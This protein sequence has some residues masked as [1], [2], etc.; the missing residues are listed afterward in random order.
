MAIEITTGGVT[1]SY[2]Y[3]PYDAIYVDASGNVNTSGNGRQV[4]EAYFNG[5]KYY[6]EEL[7]VEALCLQREE[8]PQTGVRPANWGTPISDLDIF[9]P[10]VDIATYYRLM[11]RPYTSETTRNFY[12]I[13]SQLRSVR[14]PSCLTISGAA[15][16]GCTSLEMVE[17]PSCTYIDDSAFYNT[18]L[19]EVDFPE[20]THLGKNVFNKCSLLESANLPKCTRIYEQTFLDCRLLTDVNL[21]LCTR[22]DYRAFVGCDSL[23]MIELPECTYIGDYAFAN[24][25][26]LTIVDAP[27]VEVVRYSA[28]QYCGSL[29]QL[30]FPKCME[31]KSSAISMSGVRLLTLKQGC[32]VSGLPSDVTVIYV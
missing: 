25:N 22:V 21:P 17:L 27:N 5:T 16:T 19:K 29:T 10:N 24:L 9:L 18:K 6:P 26:G 31:F 12:A 13:I 8:E 3:F 4:R 2:R 1:K 32:D 20:C 15:F 23:T 7:D 28:F 30:Y 14:L 11:R